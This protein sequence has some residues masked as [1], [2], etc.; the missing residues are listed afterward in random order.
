M[1]NILIIFKKEFVDSIRDR[2]TLLLMVVF[3]L[4]LFPLFLNISNFFISSHT[5][6]TGERKLTLGVVTNGNASD[7]MKILFKQKDIVFFEGLNSDSGKSYVEKEMLDGLIIFNKEFDND[8][9]NLIPG[10]INLVYKMTNDQ[11]IRKERFLQLIDEYK[12]YILSERFRELGINKEVIRSFNVN[13]IDVTSAKERFAGILGGF[14]PYLFIIFC[15]MGSMYP[16]IDLAAGEKERGTLETLLIAP[17]S[18]FEILVGKFGVVVITGITSAIISFIGILI[19]LWQAKEIPPEM[20]QS[21]SGILE[22]K[23]MILLITLLVPISIFFSAL[24]LSLSFYAKSFKE[25]QSIISPLTI[26]III[27]AFIG[28]MP[29]MELNAKTALIPI[30]NVSLATKAIIAGNATALLLV[31]VYASLMLLALISLLV[32][33]RLFEREDTIFRGS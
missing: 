17:V 20:V 12:Q 30:L 16:A 14:L 10:K 6:E 5:E 29:G 25:A 19:S 26:L 27:P 11:D 3:P 33:T 24:L 9:K 15:Y 18:R 28:L 22:P 8:I 23:S 13:E 1:R 31:E 7:F 2:R 21:L 32:C 4:L